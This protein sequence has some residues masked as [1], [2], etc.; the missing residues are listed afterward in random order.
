MPLQSASSKHQFFK[1]AT[2]FISRRI[3]GR[4]Q[5]LNLDGTEIVLPA[6]HNLPQYLR[7]CDQYD[8]FVPILAGCL[9][10]DSVIIDVGANC[11]D[12]LAFMHAKNPTGHYIAI[13]P[14]PEFYIY[15]EKN[16][17]A[18]KTRNPL[19]KITAIQK[20]IGKSIL[21]A[22]LA[23]AGGT[24]SAI[25][26]SGQFK[27]VPLDDICKM[28]GIKNV[29]FIKTDVDGYDYDV[30]ASARETIKRDEPLIFFECLLNTSDQRRAYD[31]CLKDLVAT[32]YRDWVVFDNYG[33][34]LFRT[35]DASEIR[36]FFDYTEKSRIRG[37]NMPFHYVDIL[38]GFD[39]HEAIISKSLTLHD[40]AAKAAI[41]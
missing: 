35:K 5:I 30:L 4:D 18:I 11:G 19:A 13:E 12:S 20:M 31:A 6:Q 9:G 23:G 34:I 14:D 21:S 40:E 8:R 22:D 32:G 1:R 36:F 41:P 17:A 29:H 33:H 16:I 28:N 2:R 38:A 27:T 26:G 25:V 39:Q 7:S 37:K 24:K 10:G 3:I 15:L